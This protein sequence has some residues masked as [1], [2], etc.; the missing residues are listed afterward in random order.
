MPRYAAKSKRSLHLHT[1]PTPFCIKTCFNIICINT[2]GFHTNIVTYTKILQFLTFAKCQELMMQIWSILFKVFRKKASNWHAVHNVCSPIPTALEFH[3]KQKFGKY[4]VLF[5]FYSFFFQE[6]EHW[7][8]IIWTHMLNK[9]IQSFSLL[10]ICS[11]N[12]VCAF[13]SAHCGFSK[14]TNKSLIY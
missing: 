3:L 5:I 14:Y 1:K 9:K 11:F 10:T 4:F 2:E 7:T 6:T 12:A 8:R 13:D